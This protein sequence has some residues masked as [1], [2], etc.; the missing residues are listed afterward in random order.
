MKFEVVIGALAEGGVEFVVIGGVAMLL[1]GSAH[2]TQDI[3]FCY[4]RSRENIRRLAA[5][6]SPYHPS[7]RGAPKGLP[8]VFD[9]ET[10]RRG[11]NFTLSTDIGDIDFLGEVAGLGDYAAVKAAS[12]TLEIFGRKCSVLSLDGLI[13]AKRA[14]GRK[15]D[16]EVL[17]ELEALRELKA[18]QNDAGKLPDKS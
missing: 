4:L 9:E 17:H 10:I 8:F 6:L 2:L 15:R 7:L 12:E 11:L 13:R 5:V 3:D 14:A 1:Q 16:L 18:M